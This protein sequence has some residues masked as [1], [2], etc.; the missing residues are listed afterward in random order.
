MLTFQDLPE[1]RQGP[2]GPAGP[3]GATGPQGP[4]GVPGATGPQGPIG[5]DGP[6]G[7]QGPAG[8]GVAGNND[9]GVIYLKNNATPTPI[10]AINQRKVVSGTMQTGLLANF[11][12]DPG[13]NS[14]KYLG[15]G[16]RFHIVA[17]FNFYE[18]SQR[19]CGFYIGH[20]TDDS[21]P[22]DP[23]GDRISESEIY[24]NASTPA[25]QP[26]SSAVQTVLDLSTD[27]RVFFIVQN[28]DAATNITVEFLKMTVTSLTAEKGDVG[29]SGPMDILTDV[30]YPTGGPSDGDILKY[31]SAIG[32]W[33]PV[34]SLGIEVFLNFEAAGSFDYVVPYDLRFDSFATSVAMT[35]TFLVGTFPYSFG[36]PLDQYDVLTVT[37]DVAGLITLEGV[38]L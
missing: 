26:I 18:G 30:T 28:K 27:D 17:T 24:A 37:T 3:A 16:G 25:N 9:V 15:P 12:K 38:R 8:S 7:P 5:P 31:N 19:T 1:G 36:T 13:T 23:D 11:I 2:P 6:I 10:T 29:P 33:E 35:T 34:S 22:L 32:Q 4:A 20:N 21:T 14:L